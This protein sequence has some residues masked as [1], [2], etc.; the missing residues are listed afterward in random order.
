MRVLRQTKTIYFI[1]DLVKNKELPRI[2]IGD[3]SPFIPSK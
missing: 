3:A 1:A 2:Q